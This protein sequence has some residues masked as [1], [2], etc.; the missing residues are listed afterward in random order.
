MAP[1]SSCARPRSH[2]NPHPN[3]NPNPSQVSKAQGVTANENSGFFVRHFAGDVL[4]TAGHFLE[5]NNDSMHSSRWLASAVGSP[6]V[7]HLFTARE[8]QP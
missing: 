1:R 7:K 6:L 8:L 2:P 4:Y 3:P 5:L